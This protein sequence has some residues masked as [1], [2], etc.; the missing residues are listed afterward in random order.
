MPKRQI[1]LAGAGKPSKKNRRN[2]LPAVG[3]IEEA[4]DKNEKETTEVV[5]LESEPE[6]EPKMTEEE[7][8]AATRKLIEQTFKALGLGPE[9]FPSC[10]EAS[11]D[12]GYNT[13][14]IHAT[15]WSSWGGYKDFSFKMVA[16]ANF[17]KR[18]SKL[19][20]PTAPAIVVALALLRIRKVKIKEG[21]GVFR[22]MEICKTLDCAATAIQHYEKHPD[23]ILQ[24][25][26]D[27][28][29]PAIWPKLI[30]DE[31]T[32]GDEAVLE[33]PKRVNRLEPVKKN[34]G[35]L[36]LQ[37]KMLEA[38]NVTWENDQNYEVEV[39]HKITRKEAEKSLYPILQQLRE[40]ETP[41][42]SL[43]KH[44]TLPKLR[45]LPLED[46]RL[47]LL[48]LKNT[49]PEQFSLWKKEVDPDLKEFQ[50]VEKIQK[51]LTDTWTDP[52]EGSIWKKIAVWAK[53]HPDSSLIKHLVMLRTVFNDY[54]TR[55]VDPVFHRKL[56]ELAKDQKEMAAAQAA[57]NEQVKKEL[58]NL[59]DK[60][61][62]TCGLM[63][64]DVS[65]SNKADSLADFSG[66]PEDPFGKRWE[67]PDISELLEDTE[68]SGQAENE[69][70]SHDA[71]P[72]A[73]ESPE[74]DLYF[75]A[76]A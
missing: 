13:G 45:V 51:K 68:R 67:L 14:L 1:T 71:Q 15:T 39:P 7:A 36:L 65:D 3:N 16:V 37:L 64:T 27:F 74:G 32:E 53:A 69:S 50:W 72:G 11:I 58:K 57:M 43:L 28:I 38:S 49:K 61:N 17:C 35:D 48:W 8:Q 47:V 2:T 21:G 31:T 42:N 46:K 4:N 22:V 18:T 60:V 44:L 59:W 33:T 26:D 30:R 25:P 62:E 12:K 75:E 6:S 76:V 63:T 70:T 73:E 34:N 19:H 5:D 23:I 24:L 54:E 55:G 29:Q 20:C 10:F 66:D 56:D 9:S 41:E 52:P 40:L